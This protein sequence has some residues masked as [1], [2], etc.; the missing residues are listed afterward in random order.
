MTVIAVR[1]PLAPTGQPAAE[2]A[3]TGDDHLTVLVIDPAVTDERAAHLAAQHG[4]TWATPTEAPA[5][6]T[7]PGGGRLAATPERAL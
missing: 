3:V 6:V 7:L 2:H 1:R 5:G 4:A